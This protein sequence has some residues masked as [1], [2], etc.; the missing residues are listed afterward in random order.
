MFA[1][2]YLES[3][4]L[5]VDNLP[6]RDTGIAMVPFRLECSVSSPVQRQGET[7][8]PLPVSLW[9]PKEKSQDSEGTCRDSGHSEL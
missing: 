7:T 1:L 3:V 4:T 6:N 5:P 8:A 9:V 2:P